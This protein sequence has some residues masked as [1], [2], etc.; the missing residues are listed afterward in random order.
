VPLIDHP[1]LVLEASIVQLIP[2]PAGKVSLTLS[3]VAMPA[4]PLPRVTVKPICDPALTLGAS[5]V[6]VIETV[7]QRTVSEAEA[8]PSPPLSVVK[9]AVLLCVPQLA[10]VVLLTTC[11]WVLVLPASVVWL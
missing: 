11:A 10:P 9:L 8:E 4:P 5:A 7:A 1:G 3:P 2:F 6:L